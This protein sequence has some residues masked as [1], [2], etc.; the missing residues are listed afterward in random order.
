M[1]L[2]Y[3][4]ELGKTKLRELTEPAPLASLAC[5]SSSFFTNFCGSPMPVLAGSHAWDDS[6]PALFS[7]A[8]S[9]AAW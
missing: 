8:R 7:S 6:F 2:R 4:S 1:Q 3:R 9:P 5:P